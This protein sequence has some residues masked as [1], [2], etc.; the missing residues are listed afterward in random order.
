MTP[1]QSILSHLESATAGIAATGILGLLMF[2]I[3]SVLK[4][5]RAEWRDVTEKIASVERELNVQRTNCLTTLQRQ[6]QAQID[7]LEKANSTLEAMHLSQVE[8]SGYLK[9]RD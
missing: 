6:G 9:G 3:R 7:L 1:L 8:M 4:S 2:P 5:A